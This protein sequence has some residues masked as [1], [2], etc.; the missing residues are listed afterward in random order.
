MTTLT[1]SI[2]AHHT[3]RTRLSLTLGTVL[4]AT[5]GVA[6]MAPQAGAATPPV[7]TATTSAGKVLVNSAGRTIYVFA[8]DTVGTS[9]CT[10][11]CVTAWPPVIVT[12][13][14]MPK[15]AGVSAKLGTIK[16]ADGALQLTVNGYPVYTYKGDSAA[17]QANGQGVDAGGL[18]WVVGP[19]GAWV[20]TEKK[21]TSGS[22]STGTGTGTGSGSGSTDQYSY[23]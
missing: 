12:A 8:T 13:K 15:A 22:G 1:K 6:T 10:G 18:W 23:Y 16:R 9:N 17:G 20:K 11:G 19:N 21:S 2:H 7:H 4:L 5:L 3:L 14:A